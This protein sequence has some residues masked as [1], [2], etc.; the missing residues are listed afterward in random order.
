VLYSKITAFD[1]LLPRL[2]AEDP[3]SREDLALLGEG[4][5]GPG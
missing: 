3:V 5:L 2:M 4:G 1:I